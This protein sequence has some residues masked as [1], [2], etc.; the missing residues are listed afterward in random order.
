MQLGDIIRSFSEEAGANEALLACDDLALLARVNQAAAQH[1][2]T[3]GEYAAGAV[4]RFA[5]LGTNEDWLGLMNALD[6]ADDPGIG[7]LAFIVTWSLT[8]DERPPA[9]R[10]AG[11]TCGGGGGCS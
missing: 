10:H 7:C 5:N 8:Q 4:R 3:V 2:E 6:R 9:A 1:D 11:C